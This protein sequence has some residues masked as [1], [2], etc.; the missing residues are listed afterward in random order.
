MNECAVL[1]L[2]MIFGGISLGIAIDRV[3]VHMNYPDVGERTAV[4]LTTFFLV[5]MFL[6]LMYHNL[7]RAI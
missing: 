1:G 4:I 7:L 5:L 6:V 3:L 2:A